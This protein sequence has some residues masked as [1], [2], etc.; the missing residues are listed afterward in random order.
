MKT[1][2]SSARSLGSAFFGTRV[3]LPQ[4]SGRPAIRGA[5][6]PRIPLGLA[7]LDGRPA[8]RGAVTP[9]IPP[10]LAVVGRT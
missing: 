8:L 6:T 5:V 2:A 9:P 1:P 10:G 4:D 7:T 3:G